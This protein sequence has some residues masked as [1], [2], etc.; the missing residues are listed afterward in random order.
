PTS[1]PSPFPSSP[2]TVHPFTGYEGVGSGNGECTDANGSLYSYVQ[3]T[4]VATPGNCATKCSDLGLSNQVG[5]GSSTADICHCYFDGTAPTVGVADQTSQNNGSGPIAGVNNSTGWQ[6]YRLVT[7]VKSQH[8]AISEADDV[9]A[10]DVPADDFQTNDESANDVPAHD[11]SANDVQA[12]DKQSQLFRPAQPTTSS[13]PAL[14][15]TFDAQMTAP[16]CSG[17]TSACT[18]PAS[19]LQ[20]TAANNEPNQLGVRASNTIDNCRDGTSGTYNTDE[21]IEWLSIVSVDPKTDQP[22][23]L[24]LRVGGRAKIITGLHAYLVG[25]SDPS[26]DYAD[27]YY[28]TDVDPPNW[29]LLG[30][31]RLARGEVDFYGFGTF[32]SEPFTILDS[33][34]SIH[35]IRVDFRYNG[36]PS[37]NACTG[38]SWADTDDLAFYVA[39]NAPATTP[40]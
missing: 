25:N 28:S 27:F 17:L 22:W 20:G 35:A 21:S 18:A 12:N 14:D 31:K 15:A 37:A 39:P 32:E 1:N 6:C 24:P 38:G 30:T 3:Y 40:L 9:P 33:S 36:N 8:W 19:L 13:A 7:Y 11:E 26:N 16:K 5:L 34:Q 10:N 23:E 29:S 4:S 2:P